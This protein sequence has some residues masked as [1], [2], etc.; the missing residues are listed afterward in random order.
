MGRGQRAEGAVGVGGTSCTLHGVSD[1]FQ[2]WVSG[3]CVSH[4]V[5]GKKNTALIC[6]I[7]TQ[8]LSFFFKRYIAGFMAALFPCSPQWNY[9]MP[10]QNLIVNCLQ[11][12]AFQY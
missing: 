10:H 5:E 9:C 2:L 8:P 4:N 1:L 7:V 11:R 6:F 3:W 12:F